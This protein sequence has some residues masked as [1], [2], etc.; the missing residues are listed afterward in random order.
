MTSIKS[1]ILSGL[2]LL[3]LCFSPQAHAVNNSGCRVLDDGD[4]NTLFSFRTRVNANALDTNPA[5]TDLIKFGEGSYNIRL[6]S[7]VTI[8]KPSDSN[9]VTITKGDASSVI[10]DGTGLGDQC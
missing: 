6:N 4:D 8:G 3:I 2:A 1:I 9:G 10:I 7:P 5:C